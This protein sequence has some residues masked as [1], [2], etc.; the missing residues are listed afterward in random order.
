MAKAFDT[1]N[2]DILVKILGYLGFQGNLLK[3]L[4][5]YLV[6]R[7]QSTSANGCISNEESVVWGIPQGSTVGPLMYI[8]Y[9]ND[10]ISCIQNCKYFMY[11]DDT[12]IYTSGTLAECTDRLTQDLTRFKKWCDRNKLTLNVHKTKYTVFGL[13]SQTRKIHNH[14]LSIDGKKI[15]NVSTY[16]YLGITLDM[17]LNYNKHLEN[18]IKSISYKSLLLAK[19]RKYITQDVAIRIYKTMILPVLE[20]GDV[21]YDGVNEKLIGKLQTVQNR[22]LRTGLLPQEHI[23]TIRLHEICGIGNLVMRRKMHLQLYMFKQK[24]NVDLVNNRTVCTRAHDAILFTTKKPNSEKYK[25][26]VFYKGALAWNS[27]S[28]QIRRSQTYTI[29]KDVLNEN[30]IQAIIPCRT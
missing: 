26:N 10:I 28:V 6:D 3:L 7:R 22:C 13:K 2:H 15:D 9:V 21:L 4:K 1:V 29:L 12:I 17:N 16:K 19:I 27:M 5:N 14:T 23:P 25:I 20:Y 30:L 8:M 11:A 18:V 24:H